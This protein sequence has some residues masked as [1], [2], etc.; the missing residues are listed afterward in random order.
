MSMM[1]QVLKRIERADLL[2]EI[3]RSLKANDEAVDATDFLED[4]VR[5][6]EIIVRQEDEYEFAHLSFQE[7]LAAA[8]VAADA[9]PESRCCLSI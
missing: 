4:V 2:E 9:E 6:S 8:Y 3:E 1:Q 5:I 7:Y